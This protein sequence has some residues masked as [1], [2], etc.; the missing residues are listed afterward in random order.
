MPLFDDMAKRTFS[1]VMD[2]MGE[3]AVWQ[4]SNGEAIEGCILFNYQ[5]KP[6]TVG[7]EY[8]YIPDAPTAEYYSGTFPGLKEET[9]AQS[10][11]YL[12][13]RGER[14]F[15]KVVETKYDGNTYVAHLELENP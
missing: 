15:V 1:A 10:H 14:Y 4:T 11:E 9:D 5:T 13:I 2:V 8:E 7:G 6:E 3:S 12:L